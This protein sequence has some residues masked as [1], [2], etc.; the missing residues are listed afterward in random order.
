[1]QARITTRELKFSASRSR[2]PGGQNVNKVNTRVE[3][4]FNIVETHL[5]T[6]DEKK[7]II[8]ILKNRINIE[9][10]LV[11]ASQSERTQLL[12]KRKVIARFFKLLSSALTDK[13]KRKAT[14][15]TE[16]SKIK[17]LEEKKK[18]GSIKKLRKTSGLSE[19]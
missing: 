1:L 7:K 14:K 19:E 12:N 8:N 6:D 17:R 10:E 4:R 2:G 16:A 18:K 5:L 15:P 9:G 13:P 11:L 3:L